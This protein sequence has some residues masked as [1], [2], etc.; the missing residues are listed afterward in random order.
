MGYH[1]ILTWQP[2]KDVTVSPTLTVMPVCSSRWEG[3]RWNRLVASRGHWG[4]RAPGLEETLIHPLEEE[5]EERPLAQRPAPDDLTEPSTAECS[6]NMLILI[7]K[8]QLIHFVFRKPIIRRG[9]F[10]SCFQMTSCSLMLQH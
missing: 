6:E 4:L 9:V 5:E 3:W 10:S 2:K 8:R 1:T 7:E